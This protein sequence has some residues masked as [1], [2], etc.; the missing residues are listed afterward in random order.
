MQADSALRA[1]AC[2]ASGSHGAS[3][4][5]AAVAAAAAG[6]WVRVEER[7]K[8]KLWRDLRRRDEWAESARGP[9]RRLGGRWSTPLRMPEAER[10]KCVWRKKR[11]R[12]REEA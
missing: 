1:T 3:A 5:V 10:E 9:M 12:S 2:L 4:A 8:G 6:V 11:G 7:K